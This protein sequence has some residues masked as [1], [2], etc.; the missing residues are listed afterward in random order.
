MEQ[1]LSS[2]RGHSDWE[3][4]QS[5]LGFLLLDND[6]VAAESCREKPERHQRGEP[7]VVSLS[8]DEIFQD[9][10]LNLDE[11]FRASR[12]SGLD[13]AYPWE[14]SSDCV[15]P[16]WDKQGSLPQKNA[17][18]DCCETPH[19]VVTGDLI[20]FNSSTPSPTHTC[21]SMQAVDI[22]QPVGTVNIDCPLDCLIG[23]LPLDPV[24]DQ[25]LTHTLP[26]QRT[27]VVEESPDS[28]WPKDL[29]SS[30]TTPEKVTD[31]LCGNFLDLAEESS[32]RTASCNVET[33]LEALIPLPFIYNLSS[34]P[35]CSVSHTD[36]SNELSA[37][38]FL[39]SPLQPGDGSHAF[40]Q[41]AETTVARL[42]SEQER[43]I[44]SVTNTICDDAS[45]VR[46]RPQSPVDPLTSSKPSV[47]ERIL[48]VSDSEAEPGT[49]P[50]SVET[51]GPPESSVL[52]LSDG[53]TTGE[54][55]AVVERDIPPNDPLAQELEFDFAQA[56]LLSPSFV[57]EQTAPV[58]STSTSPVS[59]SPETDFS[60]EYGNDELCVNTPSS[61]I[62]TALETSRD[63]NEN[64]NLA[65]ICDLHNPKTLASEKAIVDAVPALEKDSPPSSPSV[66]LGL[67]TNTETDA[68]SLD[69]ESPTHAS[70][71]TESK[72]N[73]SESANSPEN[74]DQ[75]Q[76]INMPSVDIL[77]KVTHTL[78]EDTHLHLHVQEVMS[79]Q[80]PVN[81]TTQHCQDPNGCTS[82]MNQQP[83]TQDE[84]EHLCFGAPK[85][86]PEKC[87]TPK[88]T[89]V[90]PDD[91]QDPHTFLK[92][93]SSDGNTNTHTP[94]STP[95]SKEN[96]LSCAKSPAS[97]GPKAEVMCVQEGEAEGK[98]SDLDNVTHGFESI[99]GPL[100]STLLS[101]ADGPLSQ[102]GMAMEQERGEATSGLG[103]SADVREDRETDLPDQLAQAN[104]SQVAE[105][106]L[107]PLRDESPSG[108]E[109]CPPLMEDSIVVVPDDPND[110]E[111]ALELCVSSDMI[112][113]GSVGAGALPSPNPQHDEHSALRT[114]FQA[115]DQDGDGF[116]RIEE[117]MDF[118]TAYGVEQVMSLTLFINVYACELW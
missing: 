62:D 48:A 4:D 109:T 8:F 111:M 91:L 25:T 55:D 64:T 99:P 1:V 50:K 73:P 37:M 49:A 16:S 82:D 76:T 101:G 7:G 116:V 5:S 115:L 114:V 96:T 90:T 89:H 86:T 70:S 6:D 72:P 80:A 107:N 11:L 100:D 108:E 22:L 112:Q 52:G 95:V 58:E 28:H 40:L 66:R 79:V 12:Y 63:L 65:V 13:Q 51:D 29:T 38:R 97:G 26:A 98:D 15:S 113:D 102:V 60:P 36:A 83:N 71:E 53:E 87:L 34:S 75:E 67:E 17:E 10:S 105:P 61:E 18:G 30:Q 43:D 74:T 103:Q 84:S 110:A 77:D 14:R 106:K 45:E 68:I 46:S 42:S 21:T 44:F 93:E 32:S 57:P 54:M 2:P 69:F 88:N 85:H 19:D 92:P 35:L 27:S 118:A 9:S 23:Q 24:L 94:D 56:I 3:S 81:D 104:L 33:S 47:P 78:A 59:L 39:D 31:L 20:T 117:F 41:T